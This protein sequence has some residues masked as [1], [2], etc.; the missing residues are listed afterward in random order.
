M[1]PYYLLIIF[2]GAY[3]ILYC[4]FCVR[5]GREGSAAAGAILVLPLMLVII[6]LMRTGVGG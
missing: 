4:A 1:I 2:S 5:T 3:L 6:A